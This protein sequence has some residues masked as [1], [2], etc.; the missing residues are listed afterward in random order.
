MARID[1][2]CEVRINGQPLPVTNVSWEPRREGQT[3]T[4]EKPIEGSF[5]VDSTFRG[6]AWNG[7][8]TFIFDAPPTK[9]WRR[10]REYQRQKTNRRIGTRTARALRKADRVR[11]AM[12]EFCDDEM[13]RRV[14]GRTLHTEI[15]RNSEEI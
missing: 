15:G 13:S 2:E 12:L 11:K 3:V 14:I 5:T 8:L 4:V 6:D 1:G 7:I 9:Y 10:R